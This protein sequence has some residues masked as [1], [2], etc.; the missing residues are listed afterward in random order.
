[1][2]DDFFGPPPPPRP[3]RPDVRPPEWSGPPDNE[4]GVVLSLNLE[5]ARTSDVAVAI[6]ELVA[7]STGSWFTV[8]I[9]HRLPV[10]RGTGS[11]LPFHPAEEP[12]GI[13]LG[14]QFADG[15]K[16]TTQS[17]PPRS[18]VEKP[19]APPFLMMRSAGGG[20][21]FDAHFWLW[22]LP[23]PGQLA[24]VVDW[25]AQGL[26]LTKREMDA[27]SILDAAA[28]VEQLWP[29]DRPPPDG[30]WVGYG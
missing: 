3:P 29:D 25:R 15:S 17:P 2:N 28:R 18:P 20:R 12:G 6:P 10:H 19:P 14:L 9:R 16:A 4:L 13:R 7:Y 27:Q 8:A 21:R 30:D 26:A 11:T 1:M 5:L 24:F 23:P 22:P